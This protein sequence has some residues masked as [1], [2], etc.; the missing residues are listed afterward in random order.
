MDHSHNHDHDHEHH[1][2]EEVT[3]Q[4]NYK[5][6]L[7]V[8]NLGAIMMGIGVVIVL[9]A[10]THLSVNDW[11]HALADNLSVYVM[12]YLAAKC[13]RN[14]I[15]PQQFDRYAS[16]FNSYLLLGAIAVMVIEVWFVHHKHV[17]PFATSLMGVITFFS[18]H[19]QH[20][21]LH[22]AHGHE[23]HAPTGRSGFKTTDQHVVVD[24][25]IGAVVAITPWFIYF[26]APF[27][28]YVDK[29]A[30]WFLIVYL[31]IVV[32]RNLWHQYQGK[33]LAH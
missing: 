18:S 27:Y 25:V 14:A 32:S 23:E 21:M 7:R 13:A 6:Y 22:S 30:S 28:E 33:Y 20:Q 4:K 3:S 11:L 24:R 1:D 15:T 29:G 8:A 19:F 16:W 17:N 12:W 5:L 9:F 31:S 10:D 2:H 26:R